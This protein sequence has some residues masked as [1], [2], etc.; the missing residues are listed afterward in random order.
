M[1]SIL[2]R[3]AEGNDVIT[4]TTFN[5]AM[6]LESEDVALDWAI[7]RAGV[8][9]ALADPAKAFYLLAEVAGQPVGQLMVTTEWS[10]WRNG[11][12]W[13]IQSVYVKP[14]HRR[15]GIFASLYQHLQ[16]MASARGDIRGVR[17]YVMRNNSI[18]KRTYE[19]VG[20]R[21]SHYDLYETDL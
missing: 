7:L 14:E 17:L 4:I 5:S 18:A 12:I 11:W 3:T 21:H 9:Q 16:G 20:M 2:I 15:R 13:W 8:A 1:D 10:D 6:A 19:S